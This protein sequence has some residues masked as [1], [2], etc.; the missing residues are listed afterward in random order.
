MERT[1]C[2]D[3]LCFLPA[4]SPTSS[5]GEGMSDHGSLGATSS[6]SIPDEGRPVVAE[7]KNRPLAEWDTHQVYCTS[8]MLFS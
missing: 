8:C 5:T 1:V 2:A 7:W 6:G 3:Y 4:L